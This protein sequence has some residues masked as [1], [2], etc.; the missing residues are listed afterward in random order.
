M[1]R[2]HQLTLFHSE[3]EWLCS[4]LPLEELVPHSISKAERRHHIQEA[5]IATWLWDHIF[6]IIYYFFRIL[7]WVGMLAD[8]ERES[9][10]LLHNSFLMTNWTETYITF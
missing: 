6:S 3:T 7:V 10:T 1:I 9:F 5:Y 2:P 8:R 4:F